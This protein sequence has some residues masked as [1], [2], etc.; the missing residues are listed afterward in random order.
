M[1]A[2]LIHTMKNHGL[3][4]SHKLLDAAH[5]DGQR[6]HRERF[7]DMIVNHVLES[8]HVPHVESVLQKMDQ[9]PNI[10]K[11]LLLKF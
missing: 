7:V 4:A 11:K 3:E 2:E 6:I 10:E 8:N 1:E 9:Q 5:K